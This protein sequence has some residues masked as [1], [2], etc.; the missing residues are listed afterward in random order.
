MERYYPVVK[1][2]KAKAELLQ[3]DELKRKRAD[4]EQGGGER[5]DG[6]SSGDCETSGGQGE[7]ALGRHSIAPTT[8]TPHLGNLFETLSRLDGR[9]SLNIKGYVQVKTSTKKSLRDT[10]EKVQLHHL[11]IWH[12]P[13]PLL[14]C[15][16]SGKASR[17]QTQT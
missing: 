7:G 10:N 13:D 11:A 14:S 17:R 5:K 4:N 3:N 1:P 16:C 6:D 9:Y 15:N 12:H 2:A 8:C